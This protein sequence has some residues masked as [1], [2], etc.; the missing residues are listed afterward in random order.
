MRGIALITFSTHY[1]SDLF[2]VFVAFKIAYI[3]I[4]NKMVSYVIG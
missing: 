4:D 1:P 2:G 3:L